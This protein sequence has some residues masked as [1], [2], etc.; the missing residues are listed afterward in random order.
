MANKALSDEDDE[1]LALKVAAYKD[2]AAASILVGRYTPKL[3]G[4]LTAHFGPTLKSHGVKDAVQETFL[5]MTKYIASYKREVAQ[6]LRITASPGYRRLG[7]FLQEN[8]DPR[9]PRSASWRCSI[10]LDALAGVTESAV[11]AVPGS[12]RHCA[13]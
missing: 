1:S 12:P 5:R 13:W 11:G 3:K 7:G 6:G 2:N 9:L 8:R 4:Y 10:G